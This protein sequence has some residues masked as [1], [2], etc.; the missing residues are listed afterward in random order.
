MKTDLIFKLARY[1]S[2]RFYKAYKAQNVMI[3]KKTLYLLGCSHSFFEN[4]IIHQLYGDMTEEKYG[5]V[6][7]IDHCLPIASFN[8]LDEKHIKKRFNWINL[9]PMYS[10]E[11]ISKNV[12]I[13]YHLYLLQEIKGKYFVELKG[14]EGPN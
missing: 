9:R 4:L 12:K 7:Q 2:N 5:S 14:E 11:N 8:L 1:M 3:T 13:D 10:T 6:W